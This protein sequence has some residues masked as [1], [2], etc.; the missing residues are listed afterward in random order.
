MSSNS[1][2]EKAKKKP[3]RASLKKKRYKNRIIKLIYLNK[4][5]SILDIINKM[6]LSAPTVQTLLNELMEEQFVEVKGTGTSS[7]GRRPNLF[8]LV[9]N[10]MYVLSID[11]GRH[12]TRFAIF[13]VGNKNVTGI[14]YL[15]VIL[16]S[17]MKVIDEIHAFANKVISESDIDK[18]KII[19]IGLDMPGLIDSVKGKNYTFFNFEKPLKTILEEKFRM[20]VVISNDAHAK[21]SAEFR[22]G[23][24]KGKK[25]VV[26]VHLGWGLGTGLILDGKLYRGANGFSGEFAHIP[27][28]ENGYLCN[29]GK[30]GC[31][32]TIVSAM[33]LTR[34]VV[35]SLQSGEESII[36][37]LVENNLDLVEPN[38]IL[39]AA[40][41]GDQFAIKAFSELGHDLGRG[42]AVLVQTLN[43]ELIV[44]GGI[45][46]KAE[47]YLTTSVEQSLQS[48]T[49]PNIRHGVKIVNSRLGDEANLLGCV[50]N[51]MESEY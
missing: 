21:A 34:N 46:A 30:K 10:S 41:S 37:S 50:I 24:A 25:N 13:N 6:Q 20:P 7:G 14:R 5:L 49:I 43:P 17:N 39:Q 35:S 9:E 15:P 40:K 1:E 48:Y 4:S 2:K 22:F 44:L 47:K 31:L 12:S 3:S 29:C 11:I 8:G 16:E 36:T 45:L 51:L 19:G 18:K 28:Q 38:I 27:M 26:V 33:A 32:E 42:L 23:M